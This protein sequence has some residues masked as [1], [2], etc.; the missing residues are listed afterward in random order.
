M[1]FIY[2]L[3]LSLVLSYLIAVTLCGSRLK[4]DLD[5]GGNKL[6][7]TLRLLI[8][9][10]DKRVLKLTIMLFPL[11]LFLEVILYWVWLRDVIFKR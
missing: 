3:L 7:N 6:K 4:D 1:I 8:T 10:Y 9:P 11:L 2:G 5:R